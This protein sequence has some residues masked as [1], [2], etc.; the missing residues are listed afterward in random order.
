MNDHGPS[1]IVK[2]SVKILGRNTSVSL[3]EPFWRAFEE[4]ARRHNLTISSLLSHLY[5][6]HQPPNISSMIRLFVLEDVIKRSKPNQP[7]ES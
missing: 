2:R 1:T 3:E 6:E 4:I 5:Q 7:T